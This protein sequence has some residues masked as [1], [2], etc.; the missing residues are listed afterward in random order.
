MG[1]S[2]LT[3]LPSDAVGIFHH[4]TEHGRHDL[5]GHAVPVLQPAALLDF[6]AF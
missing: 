6:A 5:P 3:R 1:W 2:I 4:L